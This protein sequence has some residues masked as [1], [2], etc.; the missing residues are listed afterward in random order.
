MEFDLNRG[1]RLNPAVALRPEPFGALAY[2]FGNRRLSF[3]KTRALV[4]VVRLLESHDSAADALAAAGVPARQRA[5]Y[6]AA[7]AALADS[8]VID[9]R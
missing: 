6:A 3:L 7:L 8:E 9:A 2:H 4:T 1:W 5:R